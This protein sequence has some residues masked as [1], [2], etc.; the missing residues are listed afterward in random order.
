M[1]LVDHRQGP[2]FSLAGK[3]VIITFHCDLDADDARQIV[4]LVTGALRDEPYFWLP[5]NVLSEDPF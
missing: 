2:Q 5:P 3:T 4:Y 1:Q